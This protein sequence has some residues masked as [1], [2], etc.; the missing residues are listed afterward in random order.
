MYMACNEVF[1]IN[2]ESTFNV[3]CGITSKTNLN[4]VDLM[5]D[6]GWKLDIRIGARGHTQ[7]AHHLSRLRY[8]TS[9][10][11]LPVNLFTYQITNC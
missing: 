4:N 5:H 10:W 3:V 9:S 8:K 6:L 2:Y 7:Q 11:Y 1:Q